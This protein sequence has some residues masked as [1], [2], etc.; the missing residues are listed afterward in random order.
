MG[1]TPTYTY[2]NMIISQETKP[3][4]ILMFNIQRFTVSTSDTKHFI[5]ETLGQSSHSWA[6]SGKGYCE[7]STRHDLILRRSGIGRG[8]DAHRRGS[9]VYHVNII[10]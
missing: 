4:S 8:H 10:I 7:D 2:V 6:R 9:E 1:D 5:K 3:C